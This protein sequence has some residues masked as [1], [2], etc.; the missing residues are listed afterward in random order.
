[1][2]N[3]PLPRDSYGG[4]PY[5]NWALPDESSDA[6]MSASRPPATIPD[7]WRGD[8]LPP[9]TAT[10]RL[11]VQIAPGRTPWRKFAML[12]S[13]TLAAL[14]VTLAAAPQSTEL[15]ADSLLKVLRQGGYTILLR[16]ARSDYTSK[17]DPDYSN[18]DRTTQRNLSGAGVADAKAIGQVMRSAGIPI[19]E[20]VSSP[21]F[22]TKET[23]QM[24]F[25]E[26][27]LT[28]VLRTLEGTPEQRALLVKAPPRGTNRALVTHHFVIERW[29]P[30]IRPGDIAE[31]EGVVLRAGAGDEIQLVGRFK[32]ADWT[33][34]SGGRTGNA[35]PTRMHGGG[36]PAPTGPARPF[37]WTETPATRVAGL[38]LHAFNSGAEAQMRAFI[39]KSL[40][41]DAN[42]TTEQ[43]VETY[44]ELLKQHGHFAVVGTDSATATEA[45]IRLR[46]NQ[47][48]L[49]LLVTLSAQDS[50]RA[51]SIR[52]ALFQGR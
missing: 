47:G 29:V 44:R 31:S 24:A 21:M 36:V 9:D 2:S 4:R 23:A 22:R 30:G 8:S 25:G 7:R 52:F 41:A 13:I 16:H 3:N 11:P 10:K 14:T 28:Q 40:V 50:T 37:V 20:V 39:E 49:Q 17:D 19:G 46:S 51:S 1:L 38:Y 43:R 33:R 32:L 15:D 35:E 18:T 45:A 42:R 26:P 5:V 12:S 34:L 27:T 6:L 48:E